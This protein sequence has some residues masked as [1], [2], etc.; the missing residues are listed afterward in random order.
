[1]I[2]GNGVRC[3]GQESCWNAHINVM[4]AE[5]SY[6]DIICNGESS[7]FWTTITGSSL[8]CNGWRSCETAKI[9]ASY[10]LADSY[11]AIAKTKIYGKMNEELRIDI[12]GYK[13][14]NKAE[15]NS[16]ESLLVHVNLYG[17]KAKL[18]IQ[19]FSYTY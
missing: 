8:E 2:L 17:F 11:N 3:N 15:I 4:D 12:T 19:S 6:T 18:F 16:A 10:I 7:C 14:A 9:T 13:A 5:P 1:M